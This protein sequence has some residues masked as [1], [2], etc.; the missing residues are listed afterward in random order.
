MDNLDFITF[1]S[2][3][4]SFDADREYHKFIH[5]MPSIRSTHEHIDAYTEQASILYS[6]PKQLIKSKSRKMEVRVLRQMIMYI[7]NLNNIGSLREVGE[8]FGGRDHS[9]IISAKN[10]VRDLLDSKDPLYTSVYNSL[11][12][13]VI[14]KDDY[15]KENL[16]RV[17][18]GN[19]YM[20]ERGV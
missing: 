16:Q 8:Y 7:C 19:L 5:A 1:L 9:T 10:K 3:K 2:N 15:K 4:Y 18:R 20:V 13:L 11:K 12:H 14:N 6:M 17:S